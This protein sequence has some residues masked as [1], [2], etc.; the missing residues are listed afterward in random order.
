MKKIY[1]GLIGAILAELCILSGMSEQIATIGM[2]V[3]FL[4]IQLLM[5][6]ISKDDTL[7]SVKRNWAKAAFWFINFCWLS[8][9]I[10]AVMS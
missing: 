4:T 7:T 2:H 5:Y 6:L 3:V 10:G 1:I 9:I 8:E